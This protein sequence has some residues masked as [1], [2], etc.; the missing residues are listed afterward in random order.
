MAYFTVYIMLDRRDWINIL[1]SDSKWGYFC[2]FY[3][4]A[5]NLKYPTFCINV[6]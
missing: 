3:V 1:M 4:S 2:I 6:Y 5:Y